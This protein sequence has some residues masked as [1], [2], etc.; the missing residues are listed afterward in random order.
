MAVVIKNLKGLFSGENFHKKFG[1]KIEHTDA[2]FVEGPID[3][4]LSDGKIKSI[5]K[6]ISSD[7]KE[8]I[9]GTGLIATAGFVDSHT[10][11]LFS[12]KRYLEYFMRWEG[13]SY[14]DIAKAGGGILSTFQKMAES[15]DEK[16][17]EDLSTFVHQMILA[18]TTSLEVKSGYGRTPEG[19][20]RLLNIIKN[21]R[22]KNSHLN[23]RSTFLGLHA[24]P[25]ESKESVYVDQMIALL[26][27]VKKHGLA[28][29]VDA[30]P[31]EG[32]FSLGESLRFSKAALEQGMKSKIHADEI[33][34]MKATEYYIHQGAVSVD[35]LQCVSREGVELLALKDTVATLLPATSFYLGIDY[36]NGR[37]L[38]DHGARVALAT[39]FNP[40]T[41]PELS[42]GFTQL[43]A[44]SQLKMTPD[45]ILCASTYN[46][47]AA[48]EMDQEKGLLIPGYDADIL[49][50]NSQTATP[51][52]E[53]FLSRLVP[54]KV[55]V[56]GQLIQ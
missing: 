1:R 18:G 33:S 22:Q 23:L 41:A 6:N 31:E 53:I 27:E 29:F 35:H 8:I 24:L 21:F 51:L 34:D 13:K 2:S 37:N 42:M 20:L 28:E 3:L 55:L 47:A 56:N 54:E 17:E 25:K 49:L 12:G 50:W 36:V 48:L 46:G 30:W 52:E 40:G 45:E 5:S 44:A 15:S 39:D 4:E 16:L 9:D 14:Q 11:S 7:R 26:P 32:F 43:L 19:E 38:I 10:H